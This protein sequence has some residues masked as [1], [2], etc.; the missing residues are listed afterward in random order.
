MT[1]EE[2]RRKRLMWVEANRENGFDDGIRRLLTELYPDNA[3]FIYELLQN[4]EDAQ[5][6]EVRFILKEDGVEFEHNG[7]RLFSIEDVDSITSI[8]VSTKREDTTNIGKFG[9]GFKAVFAYT[10][11]PE[12]TSGQFHF[13]IR[14]LVVPDTGGLTSCT[15]GGKETRFSFPFDNLAK[16]PGEARGEIEKNLRQLDE[17]TLLFLSHI[18]KIEYLLPDSAL[19]FIERKETDGNQ[20]EILVQHPDE[21]EPDS[22]A[23]LHFDKTVEVND[24]NGNPQPCRIAVAF[25]LE[26]SQEQEG[27][28][29]RRTPQAQWKIKSLEPGRVCIYFPAEK[30]TSNLRF[31]L[32][33]PFAST[34]AR[35]SVRDCSAND[36]LRDHL[37]DLVA[38]SMTVIRDQGLLTVRFLATLPNDKDNLSPFYKPIM[39]R[40]IEVFC[41]E[42]LTPM[43]QGG[44]AG[45]S[46]KFR[47]APQLSD[48]IRDKDLATIIGKNYFPPLWIA[49]PPQRNQREDNFLSMLDISEW[50]IEDLVHELSNPP[51]QLT[52]W[53]SEKSEEWHQEL[54]ALLGDFLTNISSSL[55]KKISKSMLEQ[56]RIIRC[57]DGTYRVGGESYFPSDDV[58]HHEG[59]PRVAKGVY[60]SGKNERE[61]KNARRFLEEIGVREVG[62]VERVETILKRQYSKGSIKPREQDMKRFI[63]LVEKEPGQADLFREY[64][65]FQLEN[66]KWGKPRRVFLDS[67]Y[68]ETGL[69]AYHDAL[70][71]D[72]G[73]KVALSRKYRESGIEVGRLI[74]FAKKVGAQTKLEPE[75]QPIPWDHRERDKL[76]DNGNRNFNKLEEDYDIPKLDVLLAESDLSK[77]QLL[78]RTMNKSPEKCLYARYRSNA[79]QEIKTASST[80]AWELKTHCWVPQKLD[81]EDRFFFVKPSDAIVELLPSGFQFDS[82]AQWLKA[83]GFG[84]NQQRKTEEYQHQEDAAQTAGFYSL[85]EAQEAKELLE[86]KRQDPEGCRRWQD[87]NKQKACFPTQPVTNPERRRKG[88]A[89]QH[90]NAPEKK[91]KPCTRSIRTTVATEDTRTWLMERYTNEDWQ[92]ICQVCKKEM[93]FRKHDG[94]YYFE[95]VESLSRDYFNKEHEAQFLS[96]CPVCAAMYKEFVKRDEDT[97]KDL[98]DAL[99]ASDKPEVPLALGE[100]ETSLRFVEAHWQDMKTILQLTESKLAV[101][102]QNDTWSEQDQKDL[103]T[104]SMQYAETRYP[105]EEIV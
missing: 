17:S 41:N 3:H 27:N 25:G 15:L 51:D 101:E 60:S 77:S 19:G 66:E 38:E 52:E 63:A 105:E 55:Q 10:S 46:G 92:M 88:I 53:L 16:P 32:H 11:T 43:K 22:E 59:F 97:M 26:K 94:E 91:Y 68:L 2:L 86:L 70:G 100:W 40:L 61:R 49:N 33:A 75:Q 65:I 35:D 57:S 84:K 83:I 89:E 20:I 74:E 95:A 13:R 78:W 81:T 34:V 4:A 45:A 87:G 76:R 48:L 23:F 102:D 24:E 79:S 39:N 42:K 64:Y 36:E 14:D 1:L 80:L 30:E 18:R 73:R 37:A 8:G 90:A 21:S 69:S 6:T 98:Y 12:I 71:D 85:G 50:K 5:A 28:R 9:I 31:H 99:K 47:A 72:S 93:P 56:P 104:A 44:H 96:L 29:Q 67:P 103:V 7:D 54:Y 62:E 82:G 58:E